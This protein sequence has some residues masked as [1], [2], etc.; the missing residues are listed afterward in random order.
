MHMSSHASQTQL[1][2]KVMFKLTLVRLSRGGRRG[3]VH[4]HE[5]LGAADIAE[6]DLAQAFQLDIAHAV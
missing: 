2:Y 1:N 4:V 3:G 5:G 6:R